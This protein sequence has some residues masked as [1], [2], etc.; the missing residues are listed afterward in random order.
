MKRIVCITPGRDIRKEIGL[1]LIDYTP[2]VI[3]AAIGRFKKYHRIKTD[4]RSYVIG[5]H[6]ASFHKFFDV[7]D[8]D[9]SMKAKVFAEYNSY[10]EANPTEW[11]ALQ[12]EK[13]KKMVPHVPKF[14]YK[15][16]KN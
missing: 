8:S 9:D 3:A 15:E 11:Q 12:S 10:R 1:L 6:Y 2:W 13:K 14:D 16:L 7:F 5:K 4:G